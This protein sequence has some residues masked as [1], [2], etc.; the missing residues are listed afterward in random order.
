M[1]LPSWT[2]ALD[3]VGWSLTIAFVGVVLVGLYWFVI[4]RPIQNAER[5]AEAEAAREF[6]EGRAHAGK[7]AVGIVTDHQ[8]K[9]DAIDD[10]VK[11]SE[12]AVRN[13]DP[14]ARDDATLRELCKSPSASR[15]PECAMLRPRP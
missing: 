2:R 10:R 7:D 8:D 3:P 5:A 11:G 4:V 1:K 6:G 12:D 13:A 14:A 15:R 9:T